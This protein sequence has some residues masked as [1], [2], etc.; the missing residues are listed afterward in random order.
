MKTIDVL[1]VA[2]K[3]Q[4]Y[5]ASCGGGRTLEEI[6]DSL[7]R[8]LYRRFGDRVRCRFVDVR[9]PEGEALA[10]S[11]PASQRRLPLVAINGHIRYR[12]LFSPTFIR[13][14]VKELIERLHQGVSAEALEEEAKARRRREWMEYIGRAWASESR[15]ASRS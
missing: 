3:E 2:E 4:P 11:L 7:A 14:D 1:V 10:G 12:G 6:T 8:Q 9:L 13:R 5:C 15:F